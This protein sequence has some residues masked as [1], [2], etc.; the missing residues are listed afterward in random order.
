MK[1]IS[2]IGGAAFGVLLPLL[3][4]YIAYGMVGRPGLVAGFVGGALAG[5]TGAGFLGALIAGLLAG[6]MVRWIRAGLYLKQWN[7]SCQS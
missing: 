2:D 7:R 5:A 4:G 1:L 6:F 3:A